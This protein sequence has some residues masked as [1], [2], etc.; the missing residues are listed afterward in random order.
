HVLATI[1]TSA[2]RNVEASYELPSFEGEQVCNK[3]SKPATAAASLQARSALIRIFTNVPTTKLST[4]ST[5][6]QERRSQT[7]RVGTAKARPRGSRSLWP[8]TA[9]EQ[10]SIQSR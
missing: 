2:S 8:L 6:R 1:F 10:T 9:T 7:S 4:L 5:S 3:N